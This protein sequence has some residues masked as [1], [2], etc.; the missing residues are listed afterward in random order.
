MTRLGFGFALLLCALSGADTKIEKKREKAYKG[1]EIEVV[2]AKA[3]RGEDLVTIDAKVKNCGVRPIK[4]LVLIFD[5]L[6][7]GKLVI[8]TQKIEA[9][10]PALEPGADV[11][12]HAQLTDPVRAVQ[13]QIQAVDADARDLRVAKPGPYSIE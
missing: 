8:T 7:P 13:F 10:E 4:G 12:F 3:H 11:M 6:A 1:P 2:E 9:D 5:F